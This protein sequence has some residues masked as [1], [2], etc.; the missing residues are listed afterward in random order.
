[1]LPVSSFSGQN[2]KFFITLFTF[3]WL[4]AHPRRS[5]I[6]HHFVESGISSS[7]YSNYRRHWKAI[8]LQKLRELGHEAYSFLIS[9]SSTKK[10]I[11]IVTS[12][13]RYVEELE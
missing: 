2:Y 10:Y 7:A 3:S 8:L 1:M 9:V 4:F 12:Y 13:E 11:S 6:V 5:N